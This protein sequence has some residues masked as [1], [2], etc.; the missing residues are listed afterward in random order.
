MNKTKTILLTGGTGFVGQ[1]Y[2]VYNKAKYNT[3]PISLQKLKVTEIDFQDIDVIVHLAGMAHQMQKIDNQIYF[4]VNYTLTKKFADAAKAAGVKHFIFVSTIKVFGEHQKGV[5]NE[6]SPCLPKDDPYGESKLKAEQYVQSISDEN[7]TVSILRPPLIYGPGVKGNLIRFLE[8][9]N[10]PY[11][12]PFKNLDN[13]RTMVFLDN[14][15]ELINRIIE[16]K[17]SGIFLASDESPISTE[18]LI[19]EIRLNLGKNPNLFKI[20]NFMKTM[21]GFVKPDF[22]L[23]LFGSLEMDTSDSF[24][25][26]GFIPPYSTEQGIKSMVDWYKSTLS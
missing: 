26:L 13:R 9:G 1:R 19:S 8:L 10:K 6:S 23:R 11:P 5:L 4:D 24:K 22:A 18:K 12:L 14:F 2:L 7:F 3:K 15:I 16:T 25:R 20:P 17:Q 21:L